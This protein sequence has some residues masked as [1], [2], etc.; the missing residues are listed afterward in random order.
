MKKIAVLFLLASNSIF[1]QLGNNVFLME[2]MYTFPNIE[3]DSN[4]Y[5]NDLMQRGFSSLKDSLKY[6]FVDSNGKI[7]IPP[8]YEYASDFYNGKANIISNN[9]PGL[10][11]SNSKCKL[12]PEYTMTFW[13]KDDLGLAI[14]DDHSGF[15]DPDGDVVIPL[16]YEDAFPFYKGYAAVK[17]NGKWNYLNLKGEKIFNDSLIFSYRPIIDK[18]AIFMIDTLK[19]ETEKKLISENGS[20]TFIEYG[21]KIEKI[22]LKEGLID[23]SGNVLLPPIYDEIFGYFHNGYMRIRNNGMMGLVNEKGNLVIPIIYEDL[24]DVKK[25]LFLA[26]SKNKWGMINIKNEIVIPFE[27]DKIRHFKEELAQVSIKGS[28]GYIDKRNRIVIK[29]KYDFNLLGDF[30]DGLALVKKNKKYGYINKKGEVIIPIIYNNGLPFD[31][32][33]ALVEK[34]GMNYAINRK[35]EKNVGITK[36]HVWLKFEGFRRFAE[37]K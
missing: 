26:K 36:Q 35:G 8:N 4:T 7:V 32:K 19:V 17:K 2:N 11:F 6:G 20:R 24:S 34:D 18:K 31:K 12:Y 13:Y 33:Y 14:N 28:I 16:E 5:Y 15:V 25:D 37:K 27:Y 29:P 22:Q 10:V 21:Y 1:S 30:N 23:V 3:H 9:I